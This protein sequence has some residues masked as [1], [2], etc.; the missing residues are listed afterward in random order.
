MEG[1]EDLFF[2]CAKQH[3]CMMFAM[4]YVIHSSASSCRLA[5]TNR[6]SPVPI[7]DTSMEEGSCGSRED[8]V[9]LNLSKRN[10]TDSK[11]DCSDGEELKREELPL[12]LCLRPACPSSGPNTAEELQERP[13]VELDDPFDQRQTAAL[14]LCQLSVASS[15]AFFC[16]AD[17]PAEECTDLEARKTGSKARDTTKAKTTSLKRA[18]RDQT[19]N[20]GTKTNKRAKIPERRLRRRPRCC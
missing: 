2:F 16:G 6:N 10:Q 7:S 14:A 15:V 18:N 12:D 13:D 17:P 3:V 11:P 20:H 1:K 4:W 19:K 8:L 9:P 5:E